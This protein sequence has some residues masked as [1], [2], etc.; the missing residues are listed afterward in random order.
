MNTDKADVLIRKQVIENLKTL[1]SRCI[2]CDNEIKHPLQLGSSISLDA[3]NGQKLGILFC[4]QCCRWKTLEMAERVK[5]K[6]DTNL[7]K[8]T[9]PVPSLQDIY[10]A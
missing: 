1:K 10:H 8:Y 7:S 6:I 4:R 9:F 5:E 2:G 3:P